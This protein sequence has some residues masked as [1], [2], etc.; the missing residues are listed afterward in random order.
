MSGWGL[1]L[2]AFM[3]IAGIVGIIC[4]LVAWGKLSFGPVGD[5]SILKMAILFGTI[6]ILG[7]NFIFAGFF[8]NV[9]NMGIEDN[10]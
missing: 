4:S 3:I 5:N 1:A 9:L 2:G 8:V 10:K 6:L 7:F